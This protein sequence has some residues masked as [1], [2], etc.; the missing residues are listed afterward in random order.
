LLFISYAAPDSN[1][2]EEAFEAV[3]AA[4][5]NETSFDWPRISWIFVFQY[6]LVELIATAIQ[7]ATEVTGHYCTAS[8]DPQFGH[9]WVEILS[10]LGIGPCILAIWKFRGH[11][12]AAMKVRRAVAKLA[13]VSRC[14]NSNHD[15]TL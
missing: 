3:K 15:D 11:M 1:S 7:E 9:L 2:D 10:T 6:P 13:A 5:E 8:L 4:E 12:K 14:T